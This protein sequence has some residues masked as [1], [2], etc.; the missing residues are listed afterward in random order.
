MIDDIMSTPPQKDMQKLLGFYQKKNYL[1]AERLADALTQKFPKDP[2][3]WK[4]LASI[5]KITGR[6]KKSLLL[7]HKLL[8]L[9]PEDHEVYGNMANTLRRLGRLKDAE[10]NYRFAISLKSDFAEAYSNLGITLR[11][12]GNLE[13][14]EINCKR[15]IELNPNLEH[16]H[17]NL[18]VVYNNLGKLEDA[19]ASCKK[20]INLSPDFPEPYNN[21]GNAQKNGGKL[22]DAE[23]SYKK[24]IKLKPDY[25]EAF[26]NLGATLQEQGKL[27]EAEPYYKKAIKLKPLYAEAYKNY[28][29]LLHRLNR[30]KEAEMNY[31]KALDIQPENTDT[32]HLLA[33]LR[34]HTTKT[35]P[36]V[37]IENLF[38][39]YAHRF[40]NSLL[41]EL[42]YNAHKLAAKKILQ[43]F[44][45]ESIGSILDLGCG[46]GLFGEEIKD[47]CNY[48]EGIDLSPLMLDIANKKN[49]YDK[50][51]RDNI[52]DYLRLE[53]LKFDY[54]IFTDVFIYIGDLND[55]FQLIVSRN[56][57]SGKLV[58]T[59]EITEKADYFLE[60]SGRYSHSKPYI[61]MLCNTYKYNLSHFEEIKLRKEKDKFIIG[62]LYILEF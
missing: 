5:Y 27:D 62:G 37:Y 22:G 38:N 21:L 19:E 45:N 33:A 13:D 9:S 61:E 39:N 29:G 28:G 56:E 51:S 40:D 31:K 34:G 3:A 12:L 52:L 46:T 6:L 8:E 15:A 1:E 42:S 43:N 26:N 16:A 20:A 35:A 18:A 14:A 4:T 55:I 24:A 48:L 50:L 53:R 10:E 41:N 54:F 47:F 60:K 44:N 58:F 17:N 36:K 49:I 25:T 2:F 59:T 11:D 57:S 32:S 7:N 23:L 30:L